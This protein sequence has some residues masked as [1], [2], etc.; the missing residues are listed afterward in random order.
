MFSKLFWICVAFVLTTPNYVLSQLDLCQNPKLDS[1]T[2]NDKE[3]MYFFTSSQMPTPSST[4]GLSS[5]KTSMRSIA[6]T[7]PK[8]KES[9]SSPNTGI[10]KKSSPVK[11]STSKK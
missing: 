9:K 5:S 6:S 1:I 11:S 8:V 2:Y 3:N 4:G 10:E 7:A